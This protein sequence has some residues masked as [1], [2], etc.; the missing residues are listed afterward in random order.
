MAIRPKAFT[1]SR[2]AIGKR[3]RAKPVPYILA[4]S[5]VRPNI[6]DRSGIYSTQAIRIME[7]MAARFSFRLVKIPVR[8]RD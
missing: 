1:S 8:N 6:W 3:A 5:V 2:A 7:V 4:G